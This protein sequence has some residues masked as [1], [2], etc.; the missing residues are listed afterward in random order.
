MKTISHA[1]PEGP[2]FKPSF[3]PWKWLVFVDDKGKNC[4]ETHTFK[5]IV[6]VARDNIP[7]ERNIAFAEIIQ[8]GTWD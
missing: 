5:Q 6:S 8:K 2:I 1:L 3:V 7:V 4:F